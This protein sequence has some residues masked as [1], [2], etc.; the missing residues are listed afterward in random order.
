MSKED[1]AQVC[2]WNPIEKIDCTRLFL[3]SGIHDDPHADVTSTAIRV[4]TDF[5][6]LLRDILLDSRSSLDPGSALF[7]HGTYLDKIDWHVSATG[8]NYAYA[9]FIGNQI[10]VAKYISAIAIDYGNKLADELM[11]KAYASPPITNLPST[12]ASVSL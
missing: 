3:Y 2:L 9:Y 6:S 11:A 8:R 7:L 1:L 4:D 12:V 10:S 5:A